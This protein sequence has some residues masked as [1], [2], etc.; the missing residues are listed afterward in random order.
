MHKKMK[1]LATEAK[2]HPRTH[3]IL[4]SIQTANN[5]FRGSFSKHHGMLGVEPLPTT[6]SSKWQLL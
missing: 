6:S 1:K 3:L 5:F 4:C 2:L